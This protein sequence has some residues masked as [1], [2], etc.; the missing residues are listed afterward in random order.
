MCKWLRPDRATFGWVVNG[1]GT[2]PVG[3]G[4]AG[5]GGIRR[6]RVQFGFPVTAGMM[7]TVGITRMATG[8]KLFFDPG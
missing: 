8:G 2:V 5:I 7:L 6:T 4:L 1:H 3:I